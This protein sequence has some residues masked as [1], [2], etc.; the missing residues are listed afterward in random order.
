[1]ADQP[2]TSSH[3]TI[4]ARPWKLNLDSIQRGDP[5]PLNSWNNT[6][7]QY[8]RHHNKD[9]LF[10]FR[11]S[12]WAWKANRDNCGGIGQYT[13]PCSVDELK[14][15]PDVERFPFYI[16]GEPSKPTIEK[17]EF[18]DN[19]QEPFEV[20][21][22]ETE[23][24]PS[25]DVTSTD[26]SI[27]DRNDDQ[28]TDPEKIK[29]AI[30]KTISGYTN[31]D[32][33]SETTASK[34]K[35]DKLHKLYDSDFIK[36]FNEHL[37][38]G[39]NAIE[40]LLPDEYNFAMSKAIWP[41]ANEMINM[42]MDDIGVDTDTLAS[43]AKVPALNMLLH[44]QLLSANNFAQSRMSIQ[45]RQVQH[46]IQSIMGNYEDHPVNVDS[47]APNSKSFDGKDNLTPI[48]KFLSF[49]AS[50]SDI[51]INEKRNLVNDLGVV[52][53]KN[54]SDITMVDFLENQRWIF[55]RV[56]D[57]RQKRSNSN[58]TSFDLAKFRAN[59]M[60]PR[61]PQDQPRTY[62]RF[63]NGNT[64]GKNDKIKP[65]PVEDSF[66]F[67]NPHRFLP[68]YQDHPINKNLGYDRNRNRNQS[69]DGND[70]KDQKPQQ[71][72]QSKP[73]FWPTPTQSQPESELEPRQETKEKLQKP[74]QP[75]GRGRRRRCPRRT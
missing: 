32:Q 6:T 33:V 49:T 72:F 16:K 18:G 74:R 3:V 47:F 40:I 14:D 42:L 35:I 61:P 50:T 2:V 25:S 60:A 67:A 65:D 37:L 1:M 8:L 13:H 10:N 54:P 70:W 26:S 36:D 56:D 20:V 73:E 23:L 75:D 29:L 44:W 30:I 64:R 15:H 38:M 19:K 58:L 63:G 27:F 62:N 39:A 43:T 24:N 28:I 55:K 12:Q 17:H 51:P 4:H 41:N 31:D 22:Y 21:K 69:R 57:I 45:Q 7:F 34:Y 59:V 11:H 68:A 5:V 9:T 66:A 53:K 46:Q 71:K 52:I 48:V